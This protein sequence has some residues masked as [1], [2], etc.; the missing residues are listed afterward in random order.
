MPQTLAA[1][2]ATNQHTVATEVRHLTNTPNRADVANVN[3]YRLGFSDG[4][5]E[6][7]RTPH[8]HRFT[9]TQERAYNAGHRE[10]FDLTDNQTH[11][12]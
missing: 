1:N 12:H 7:P 5:D 3:A 10:G 4:F 11:Q 9:K 8:L 2:R 6:Q